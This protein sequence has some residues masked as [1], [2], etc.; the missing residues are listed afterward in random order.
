VRKLQ[1]H[2]GSMYC[3]ASIG[4]SSIL[5]RRWRPDKNSPWVWQVDEVFGSRSFDRKVHDT[6]EGAQAEALERAR[7]VAASLHEWFGQKKQ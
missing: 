5:V 3:S 6:I 4:C 2:I 1:W 7:M